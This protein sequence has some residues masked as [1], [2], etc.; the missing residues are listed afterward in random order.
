MM[1]AL[2]SCGAAQIN[3][4]G[5]YD[6]QNVWEYGTGGVDRIRHVIDP[7]VLAGNVK[8]YRGGG[9]GYGPGRCRVAYRS[10]DAPNYVYGTHGFRLAR[11]AP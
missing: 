1:G 5:L 6:M 9:W 3:A 7:Q 8:G 2:T 4:W 10:Y 11:N